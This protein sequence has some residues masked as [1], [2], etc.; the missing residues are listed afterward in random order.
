MGRITVEVS[1]AH[2]Q[3]V[4]Q[5]RSGS[6]DP[7][8]FQTVAVAGVID[9]GAA[10]L[11]LPERIASALRLIHAGETT[12]RYADQRTAVRSMVSN[13]WLSLE[14]REGVFSAIVEPD[15]DTALIGAIVL[16]ELDLVVDCTRQVVY[17]RDPHGIISEVE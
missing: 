17:P 12:V 3:Q 2:N 14:G 15:R 11:V 1:V 5:A 4:L 7:E 16:E 9:T 10:R 6:G 13:V 8:G